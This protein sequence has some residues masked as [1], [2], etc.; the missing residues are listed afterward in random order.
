MATRDASSTTFSGDATAAIPATVVTGRQEASE[1]DKGLDGAS[2]TSYPTAAVREPLV[3]SRID[4][5]DGRG[6]GV[7]ELTDTTSSTTSATATGFRGWGAATARAPAAAAA[8]VA[9]RRGAVEPVDAG[10]RGRALVAYA[11]GGT[12]GAAASDQVAVVACRSVTTTPTA[13]VVTIRRRSTTVA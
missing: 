12:G 13:T 5:G 8:A 6:R 11:D 9:I 1:V 7:G 10:R 4:H 2:G 3:I